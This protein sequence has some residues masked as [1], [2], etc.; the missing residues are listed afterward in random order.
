MTNEEA[1]AELRAFEAAN[2]KH[3]RWSDKW[4]ERIDA[5]LHAKLQGELRKL[6]PKAARLMKAM[7]EDGCD[8]DPT[9]EPPAIEPNPGP[10]LPSPRGE[11]G[12][13][14]DAEFREVGEDELEPEPTDCEPPAM[15][16]GNDGDPPLPGWTQEAPP[17][18]PPGS[19]MEA[20]ERRKRERVAR[21]A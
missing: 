16:A 11:P 1:L 9:A 5:K 7:E 4:I 14:I 21:R 10:E 8:F 2:R 15:R 20:P 19:L 18:L 12:E 3:R 17:E 13:I 6:S